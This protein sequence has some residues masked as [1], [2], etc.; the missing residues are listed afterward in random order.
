MPKSKKR[1]GHFVVPLSVVD[2][3]NKLFL[4]FGSFIEKLA[5]LFVEGIN[6]F[7]LQSDVFGH[8]YGNCERLILE[9]FTRLGD[10]DVEN[11]LVLL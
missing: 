3:P 1:Q 5:E 8:F 4:K 7:A 9:S 11:T 10:L 2:L 6:L